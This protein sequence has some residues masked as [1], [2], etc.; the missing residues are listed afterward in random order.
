MYLFKKVTIL[1]IVACL[2]LFSI[3]CKTLGLHS[4]KADMDKDKITEQEIEA[5]MQH[6]AQRYHEG[7]LQGAEVIVNEILVVEPDH[8]QALQYQDY[9]GNI[10]YCTIYPGDTLSEVAD[11]YYGDRK[12]WPIIAQANGIHDPKRIKSYERLRVP[13]FPASGSGKDELG[14]LQQGAFRGRKV[15]KIIVIS[16]GENDS[17]ASVAKRYYGNTRYRFFLADYN[18]L[19]DR[20]GVPEI[21]TALKVPV[22]KAKARK[23]SARPRVSVS[24][25][26]KCLKRAM[27]D[28]DK[29]KY[30]SACECL[31]QIPSGSSY[32]LE[33][34]PLITRCRSEGVSYYEKLGDQA[35]EASDP[36]KACAYWQSALVL[37]PE[38]QEVRIKLEEAENLIEA[39]KMIPEMQ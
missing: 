13:W 8:P 25:E 32:R 1:G 37:D 20:S 22:L 36:K 15:T 5:R 33:A 38:N 28:M 4:K 2:G 19:D 29:K 27:T 23:K 35:F 11:Y 30:Q 18:L 24:K 14:R 21:G 10:I 3:H 16:V 31:L 39:L 7:D 34:E 9:L 26:K 6:A 12:M 17:L